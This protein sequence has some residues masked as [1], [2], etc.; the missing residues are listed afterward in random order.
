MRSIEGKSGQ[1]KDK[2][3]RRSPNH[4]SCGC[5]A[6]VLIFFLFAPQTADSLSFF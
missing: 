1:A 5:L 6:E 4:C 2:V 3:I